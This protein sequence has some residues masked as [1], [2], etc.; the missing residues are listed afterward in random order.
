MLKKII[1]IMLATLMVVVQFDS[2]AYAKSNIDA[3]VIE[4]MSQLMSNPYGTQKNGINEFYHSEE[5]KLPDGGFADQSIGRNF[6][7]GNTRC[8]PEIEKVEFCEGQEI[9]SVKSQEFDAGLEK[10]QI[11]TSVVDNGGAVNEVCD[12]CKGIS[13]NNPSLEEKSVVNLENEASPDKVAQF[14]NKEY[15]IEWGYKDCKKSNKTEIDDKHTK[16]SEVYEKVDLEYAVSDKHIKENIVLNSKEARK[17]FEIVYKIGDLTARQLD[18]KTVALM[19]QYEQTVFKISAPQMI[20]A[21]DVASDALKLSIKHQCNGVLELELVCD[22]NWLD[23]EDRLYPVKIDPDYKDECFSVDVSSNSPFCTNYRRKDT[24][25]SVFIDLRGSDF[26]EKNVV[27]VAVYGRDAKGVEKNCTYKSPYYMLEAGKKYELYNTVAESGCCD[28]QIRFNGFIGQRIKGKWSPDYAPD[29][30]CIRIGDMRGAKGNTAD[31]EILV[32]EGVWSSVRTKGNNSSVYVNLEGAG[33]GTVKVSIFGVGGTM[34]LGNCTSDPSGAY[35]LEFGKK[36]ELYNNVKEHGFCAVQLRFF[37]LSGC[38]TKGRWSPDYVPEG[39]CITLDKHGVR[40]G[41]TG[42][43]AVEIR[44][45][46]SQSEYI[47]VPRI[48]QQGVAST[49]CESVSAVMLLNH[50]GYHISIQDF[51]NKFLEKRSLAEGPD[52][53]SAFIGNPYSGSGFG[54]FAP[55]IAKAMNKILSNH[56]AQVIRG[57]SLSELAN[58]YVKKGSPVL[59]WATMGMRPVV[60]KTSWNIGYTD[61]NAVYRMGERFTWPGNEHCLVLVGCNEREFIVNDPL[62]LACKVCGAYERTLME[63]RFAELGSQAVV[64][65]GNGVCQKAEIQYKSVRTI[66]EDIGGLI[67]VV[68]QSAMMDGQ[69]A[70]KLLQEVFVKQYGPDKAFTEVVISSNC[71]KRVDMMLLNNSVAELYE[72]KPNSHLLALLALKR[73]ELW[74]NV[75]T[76]AFDEFSYRLRKLSSTK[77]GSNQLENYVNI[78]ILDEEF[79][80]KYGCVA[81]V[82]GTTFRPDGWVL[83]R[84]SNPL[85]SVRYDIYY[86]KLD[87]GMIYWIYVDSDEKVKRKDEI[88]A[89]K[90]FEL[91]KQHIEELNAA[92]NDALRNGN[93]VIEVFG[94]TMGVGVFILIITIVVSAAAAAIAV[95]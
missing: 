54:C 93:G 95:I 1:S 34:P 78:T 16:Y 23:S 10:T 88:V 6:V 36:Y 80:R 2:R 45:V 11:A 30:E 32:S 63:Q 65:T 17:V 42:A 90:L 61:E 92:L 71:K 83:K 35:T 68:M 72:I 39:G 67:R 79:K 48:S 62:Q 7:Q 66:I 70:H 5:Q 20:D 76:S 26:K 18:D 47:D 82:K 57:K 50:Y 33:V 41:S 38:A 91:M 21:D 22:N 64:I 53:N 55:C 40:Y 12:V 89:I 9:D 46:T 43:P 58:E 3:S 85:R 87:P 73:P 56:R 81:T 59:V 13:W 86:E 37:E 8:E 15:S 75:A 24:S 51:I 94:I 77:I 84:K 25:T 4:S 74:K 14:S 31:S 44:P 29:P 49:G 27:M 28:V 52:P 69:E 60:K 19:N